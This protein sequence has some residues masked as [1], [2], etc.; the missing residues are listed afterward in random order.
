M[1]EEAHARGHFRLANRI[2]R[3]GPVRE[4]SAEF[5]VAYVICDSMTIV[6]RKEKCRPYEA[7]RHIIMTIAYTHICLQM[8]SFRIYTPNRFRNAFAA[9]ANLWFETCSHYRYLT[10]QSEIACPCISISHVKK[11]SV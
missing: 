6:R 9:D 10:A 8:Q 1:S 5:R 3:R 11:K 4:S 2:K 7:G